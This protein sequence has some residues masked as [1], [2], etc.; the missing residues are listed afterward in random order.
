[1]YRILGSKEKGWDGFP[2]WI[3]NIKFPDDCCFYD[4]EELARDESITKTKR[5]WIS[6]TT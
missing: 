2:L 4:V 1:M 6:L 5:L 3:P